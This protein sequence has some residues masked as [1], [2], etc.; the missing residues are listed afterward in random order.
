METQN[1][2]SRA[3]PCTPKQNLNNNKSVVWILQNH[4]LKYQPDSKMLMAVGQ[5]KGL[6]FIH[7]AHV[8]QN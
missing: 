2:S 4:S 8:V 1:Y 3:D 6:G 5:G 7:P